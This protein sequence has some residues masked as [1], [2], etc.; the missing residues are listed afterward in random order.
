VHTQDDICLRDMIVSTHAGVLVFSILFTWLL[1]NQIQR[2]AIFPFSSWMVATQA[3]RDNNKRLADEMVRLYKELMI[4]ITEDM[5]L[6]NTQKLPPNI[7]I[8]DYREKEA[9]IIKL[10]DTNELFMEVNVK[11]INDPE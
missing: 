6:P 4:F 11:L 5:N 10:I 8:F 1:A 2:I 3:E 9:V 7:P